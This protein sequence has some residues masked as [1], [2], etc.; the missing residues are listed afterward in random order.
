M[1]ILR[2]LGLVLVL[3]VLRYAGGFLF[4]PFIIFPG[5]FGAMAENASYFRTEFETLDWVTSYLY[6][7]LMWMCAVWIFHIA[8]PALRGSDLA[9]SLKVFGILWL[10]FAAISAIYMNHYSHPRDFYLWNILDGLLIFA[11]VAVGNGLLYRRMMGP[12]AHLGQGT[13]NPQPAE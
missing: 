3:N 11:L 4:E 12:Y 2:F 6:N 9:C 8:R 5:L 13:D 7:F 10:N 1:L